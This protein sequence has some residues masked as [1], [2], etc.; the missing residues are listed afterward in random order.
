MYVCVIF[1]IVDYRYDGYG[2]VFVCPCL[3]LQSQ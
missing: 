1:A 2:S 3:F